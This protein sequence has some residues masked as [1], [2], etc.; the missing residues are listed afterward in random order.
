V[1]GAADRARWS[2]AAGRGCAST[3]ASAATTRCPTAPT[4][5]A[6]RSTFVRSHAPCIQ[7][8]SVATIASV[9]A[10]S[11]SAQR[12]RRRPHGGLGRPRGRGGRTATTA[13]S[14]A[15]VRT[16][17]SAKAEAA[18][19]AQRRVLPR[20]YLLARRLQT[21]VGASC[22]QATRVAT[23]LAS[24][25]RHSRSSSALSE[26]ESEGSESESESEELLSQP[27][28][29][30][31]SL[32]RSIGSIEFTTPCGCACALA[33]ARRTVEHRPCTHTHTRARDA[34]SD[35]GMAGEQQGR[36]TTR[37]NNNTQ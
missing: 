14:S 25:W 33:I 32:V 8:I 18:I 23:S 35:V 2:C 1:R 3:G 34:P 28:S 22:S 10:T 36:I 7:H 30:W 16:A 27:S 26:S 13:G 4:A 5:L 6:C 20:S 31:W 12:P 19:G 37:N 15:W 11:R 17:C 9:T 29:S 24:R 21:S